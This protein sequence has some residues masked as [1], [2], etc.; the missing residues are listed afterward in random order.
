MIKKNKK[1]EIIRLY[2]QVEIKHP[3][4]IDIANKVGVTRQYVY[5][6]IQ[7]YLAQNQVFGLKTKIKRKE[8]I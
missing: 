4:F 8:I 6:V 1:K 2:E 3:R 7:L 5:Q